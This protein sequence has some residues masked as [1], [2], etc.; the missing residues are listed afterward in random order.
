MKKIISIFLYS[1]GV[2]APMTVFAQALQVTP[3]SSSTKKNVAIPHAVYPSSFLFNEPQILS[4]DLNEVGDKLVKLQFSGDQTS[5]SLIEVQSGKA[6]EIKVSNIAYASQVFFINDQLIALQIQK[7]NYSFDIIEISSSKVVANIPSNKFI[8]STATAAFFSNQSGSNSTIEKFEITSKKFSNVGTISGEVFGWYFSKSK[9]IV[10]AAVHSNMLSK[11]YAIENN[12]LGKSLFEFSSNYYFET[13][14]CNSTGD[15]FYGITNFQSLTT[16]ACAV[17]KSGIKSLNNKSGESCTDVFTIGNDIALT[18]NNINAAE[19]QESKNPTI[20]KV[21]TFAR[22][23]FK[24][25]SIQLID[26]VEKSNTALFSLQGETIKPRY[27]VWTS[28]SAKPISSDKYEGKNLTFIASE[29]AQIQTGETTPQTGRMYLP[30]KDEKTSYPLVIYI[31]KNIFLPY[32]N[33]FNPTVQHLCQ[34]GYAVFV[35][36][37]RYSFRPKIGLKYSDLVA[38]FPEDISLVHEFL[39]KEYHLTPENSYILGEGLG[40]YLA[41]NAIGASREAFS[42]VLINRLNFPGREYGQD[43]LAA[44]MLGEDAQSKW[45]TLDRTSLSEKI[46]YLSY[47]IGKSDIEVRLE[48]SIKQNKIKWTERTSENKRASISSKD[49]DGILN[50]L[51]HLSQ[52]ETKII[53]D[54][55]KVEVKKK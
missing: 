15:V 23:S 47:T 32:D 46:N 29:V 44:R 52:M 19:Y 12:K 28:N 40:G 18:T 17:S 26:Y 11:I 53:E 30:T 8:G 25:S 54:K 37:T 3:P 1:I 16:Y 5:L 14:G 27:F 31:P 38:S 45:N 51:E 21:L 41:L 10:G 22:E 33:Q 48:A 20:Q 42:G 2:V 9:G 7:E 43:L 6:T 34:N 13:K 55:P 39:K 24:G 49:L 50:W 4:L 36:N 35:W